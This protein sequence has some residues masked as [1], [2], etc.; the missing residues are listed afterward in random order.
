MGIFGG[1]Y[2]K[3]GKG[4][5]KNEPKKKGL[6]L[7]FD[8]LIRKFSKIISA[9]CLYTLTSII[10]IAILYFFA[11]IIFSGTDIITNVA[12]SISELDSEITIEQIQGSIM[13][14]L[15]LAFA[16]GIFSLWGSGPATAAYA[17]IH[18]CFTRGEPVWVAS[19]GFDKFKE[20]FK[21]GMFVLLVDAI[22]IVFGLNA[23]HFYYSVFV[24][25]H[26]MVWL[27]LCYIIVVLFI[28]YSMMHPY[29]YQ[30]MVTFECK[31]G[32]IYK[33]ALMITIAKLPG[34]I[35]TLIASL[36]VILL[37]FNINPL[38]A[39][40]L[41]AVIGLCLTSYPGHFYAARVIERS[42]LKDMK[43]KQSKIEYIGEEE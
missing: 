10:W 18:R 26:N 36:A 19:D 1:G 27:M 15:Q 37:L 13:V 41:I 35:L 29:I 24:S 31:I 22:I 12:S 4:V 38:I 33:N 17:Y 6:F 21:Q 2:D 5:D 42:I 43:N 20:N 8:I 3:P 34:N 32:T 9:N 39:S 14:L 40:L 23:A 25:S 16:M 7:F 30:L 28:I 11:G